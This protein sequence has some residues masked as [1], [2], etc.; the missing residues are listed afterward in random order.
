Q[1]CTAFIEMIDA[2]GGSDLVATKPSNRALVQA[3]SIPR[4]VACFTQSGGK[5]QLR[6]KGA[7]EKAAA[8][9]GKSKAH[10]TMAFQGCAARYDACHE[11]LSELMAMVA[12][13]LLARIVDAMD[14]LFAKW[15]N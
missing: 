3:A 10:G 13:E 5:R 7:W 11:V 12:G 2:L 1:A 6:T 4:H 9:A 14:Q 15:R 8:A